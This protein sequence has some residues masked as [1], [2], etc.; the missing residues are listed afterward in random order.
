M[1]V[2]NCFFE[3]DFFTGLVIEH[4][5]NDTESYSNE[6][7]LVDSATGGTAVCSG[8]LGASTGSGGTVAQGVVVSTPQTGSGIAK[9]SWALIVVGLM[10]LGVSLWR[11][12]VEFGAQAG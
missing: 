9:L 1:T 11:R 5:G 2:P 7:R 3:V 12:E 10:L 6:G 4:F 8:V